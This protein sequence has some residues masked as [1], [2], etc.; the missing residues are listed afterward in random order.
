MLI[1]SKLHENTVI[2]WLLANNITICNLISTFWTQFQLSVNQHGDIFCMYIIIHRT[3]QKG[4]YEALL[5][6][7]YVF[8]HIIGFFFWEEMVEH[9]K[10][11]SCLWSQVT[12][13]THSISR[14]DY[15]NDYKNAVKNLLIFF[16]RKQYFMYQW[17]VCT[18]VI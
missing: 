11:D 13:V 7:C 15:K 8:C 5:L 16:E 12:M 2:I 4:N 6:E 10:T 9:S 18:N 1:Y 3:R 14:N 17:K